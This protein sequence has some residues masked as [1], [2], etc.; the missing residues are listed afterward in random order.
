MIAKNYQ[1]IFGTYETL[2]TN[3][4]VTI[5]AF[6]AE[7]AFHL[8]QIAINATSAITANGLFCPFLVITSF[9]TS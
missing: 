6:P 3:L 7:L 4:A 8:E 1:N 2:A 5:V 9:N